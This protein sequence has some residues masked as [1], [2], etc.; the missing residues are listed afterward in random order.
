MVLIGKKEDSKKE[1]RKSSRARSAG[2][3]GEVSESP[4][5]DDDNTVAD[6]NTMVAQSKI[7]QGFFNRRIDA[8]EEWRV[9]GNIELAKRLVNLAERHYPERFF[10]CLVVAREPWGSRRVEKILSHIL[11][12]FP[13]LGDRISVLRSEAN[14]R[15]YISAEELAEIAG[16]NA[17]AK[18]SSLDEI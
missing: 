9:H 2:D 10:Q 1:V 13:H 16:G 6:Q 3:A 5:D 15:K 12:P 11:A 17:R 8:G 18:K 7:T 14:L 4:V